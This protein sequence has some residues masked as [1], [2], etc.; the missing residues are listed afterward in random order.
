MMIVSLPL[1]PEGE[2]PFAV[3]TEE[4]EEHSMEPGPS[5]E[6]L[7][8]RKVQT[9]SITAYLPPSET[10]TG[11]AVIICPGGGYQILAYDWE[12]KDIAE[13]W[14]LRGVAA[15]V[16]KYRLPSETSQTMPHLCP[17]IDV[18]RAIRLVRAHATEWN[19]TGRVGIK[20]FS[21]GGHL[22]STVSTQYDAGDAEAEDMVERFSCR[23]D[24]SILVYPVISFS[25]DFAHIGSRDNLLRATS[26]DSLIEK[27]SAE[28]NVTAETPPALLI[29]ALDD[30]V[31]SYEHSLHYVEALRLQG[32]PATM[33]LYPRGEHG[34]SLAKHDSYLSTWME[35]CYEWLAD[36][37]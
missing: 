10:A 9:P 14:A 1:Y 15:I 33:H 37:R 31:V 6:I 23:P 32:V 5:G 7:V 16:L 27:F 3:P 17:L 28:L 20:G 34:F 18:Q 11:D 36:F 2:I 19:I 30:S 13:Q 8:V 25:K 35:R 21:A 24:F 26:D 4:T 12:G 22:A 29:H